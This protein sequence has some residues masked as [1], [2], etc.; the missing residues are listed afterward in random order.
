M[1]RKKHKLTELGNN[2]INF[3]PTPPYIDERGVFARNYDGQILEDLGLDG[4]VAQANIS[5]NRKAGTIRG[6]HFLNRPYSESKT[7]YVI[8]GS[9]H[10]KVIDL[11]KESKN[12]MTISEMDLVECEGFVNISE[13]CAVGF[14][15]LEDNS[16]IQYFMSKKYIAEQDRGIRY[17]DPLFSL[18]WP[19]ALANISMRDRSFPN[20]STDLI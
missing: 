15:T 19:L 7:L 14:Q 1:S 5:I 4:H 20:F 17:D 3:V 12:F 11:R 16:Y 13:G 9:I 8:S 18:K 2:P 6:F 10:L